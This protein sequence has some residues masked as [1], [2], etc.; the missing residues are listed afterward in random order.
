MKK[1]IMLTV[2]MM[3]MVVV[4]AA[5]AEIKAE[6]FS[7]TPFIGGYGFEG[8]ENLKN[9]YTAGLRAGYN[10]TEHLGVEGFFNYVPAKYNDADI[11][12]YGYGIE[13]IY[14]LT[15]DGNFVPF[16]AI[17]IG[18]ISYSIPDDGSEMNKFA[19]DYGAGLKYFIT[20]DIALRTDVRQ[21]F[22]LNERYNDLLVTFGIDFFFGGE[23]KEVVTARYEEPAAPKEAVVA[24]K[25]EEPAPPKEAVVAPKIEEPAPPKEAVVSSKI[26]EPAPPKEAGAAIAAPA[27]T[28]KN[29]APVNS[30]QDVRNFVAKWLTSWQSGDMETYLSCYDSGFHSKGKTLKSWISYKTRVRHRSKNINISID[31][32]Q[33]SVDESSAT[34]VFTQSY[35]SSILKDKG[36][37]TLKLRK[38]NNEWKIYREIMKK[39]KKFK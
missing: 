16:L 10:F 20:D 31:D 35:S 30:E 25:I 22:Y 39:H 33:V 28:D 24:P 1:N 14:H 17:G 2:V 32:L 19:V 29:L 8:N 11:N 27:V 21:V 9:T 18:G 3:L 37:K 5:H 34:A 15:P 36:K 4:T 6:S 12:L 13:G 26:E 7:V 23:K 38:I